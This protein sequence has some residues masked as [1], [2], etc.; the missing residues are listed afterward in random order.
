M[1]LTS[2]GQRVLAEME[3]NYGGKKGKRVFH[4]TINARKKG[5]SQWHQ[6]KGK[7]RSK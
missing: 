4:A 2:T 1:P 5:S 3:K 6:R 7:V